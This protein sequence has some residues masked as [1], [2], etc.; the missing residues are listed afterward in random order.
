MLAVSRARLSMTDSQ[1]WARNEFALRTRPNGTMSLNRLKPHQ[2]YNDLGHYTEQ[3]G[4]GMAVSELL[5]QSVGD[6]VRVFPALATGCKASFTNLRTQGGFLVSVAGSAGA[7]ES[8]RIVS[9]V[10]GPL[11]LLSPWPSIVV[12]RSQVADLEPLTLDKSRVVTLQ[13]VTGE[14]LTFRAR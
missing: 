2:G 6:V 9:T 8:L 3:F 4:A 11:R 14:G 5:L 1:E 10:G 13:T 7:V 12:K